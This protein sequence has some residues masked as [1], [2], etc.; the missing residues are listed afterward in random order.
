MSSKE[1]HDNSI[2][3]SEPKDE[4]CPR[5]SVCSSAL[6]DELTKLFEVRDR[7]MS[8]DFEELEDIYCHLIYRI[9]QVEK[10]TDIV[11]ES[12]KRELKHQAKEESLMR[13]AGIK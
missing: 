10:H 2:D 12:R 6:R 11:V 8:G 7:A 3:V 9:S 4:S 1:I 13:E 5:S